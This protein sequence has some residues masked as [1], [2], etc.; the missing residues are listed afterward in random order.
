MTTK[1][2]PSL[3]S[4]LN[5]SFFVLIGMVMVFPFVN[6]LTLSLE[7]EQIAS[8]VGSIH[9]FPQAITLKAYETVFTDS[10]IIQAFLNSVFVTLV[11][12]LIGTVFT[13][14]MAYGLSDAK[15]PGN[16]IVSYLVLFTMMFSGGIIPLYILIKDLGLMNTLWSLILPAAVVGYNVILMRSF[17]RSIP[18]SL[19]ESASMDGCSEIGIFFRIVLPLSAPIIATVALFIGVHR[20]NSFFDAVMYISSQESKTLQL[21]LREILL[22]NEGAQNSGG[23][24]DLGTNVKMA[25]AIVSMIPIMCVYPFL[26]KYFTKGIL[27]GGVKG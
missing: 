24:L 5:T 18:S 13:G 12:S 1:K 26:Q 17:F 22:Q 8:Q 10:G 6:V 2:M 21:I 9:L 19:A 11:G 7:P 20:W 14:M 15:M 25:I 23:D 16:R 4:V 27:L 3:F